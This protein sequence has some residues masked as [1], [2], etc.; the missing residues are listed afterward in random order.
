[1]AVR[2]AAKPRFETLDALTAGG[3]ESDAADVDAT[4]GRRGHLRVV[5]EV[6]HTDFTPTAAVRQ[7]AQDSRDARDPRHSEGSESS[8]R[9]EGSEG[10]HDFTGVGHADA[11]AERYDEA[12]PVLTS[13]PDVGDKPFD[14]EG[15]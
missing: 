1:D 12:H 10:G 3:T 2:E 4:H 8:E 5:P 13:T 15:L 6:A 9:S 14:H 7:D 11:A